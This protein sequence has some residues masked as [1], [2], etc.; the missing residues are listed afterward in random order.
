M[1]GRP[2]GHAHH[3]DDVDDVVALH[4]A[5]RARLAIEPRHEIGAVADDSWMTFTANCRSRRRCSAT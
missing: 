5:H 1:H 3:V 2:F 4:T